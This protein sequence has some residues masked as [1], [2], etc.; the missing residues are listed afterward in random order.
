MLKFLGI[1]LGLASVVFLAIILLIVN[2]TIA[3]SIFAVVLLL[4]DYI[5]GTSL[6]S[7][8]AIGIFVAIFVVFQLLTAKIGRK[9]W[10]VC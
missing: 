4:V 2:A 7:W 10:L 1:G 5:C 6:F 9:E 8:G 3:G